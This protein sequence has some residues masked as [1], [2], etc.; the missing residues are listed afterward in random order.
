[1][2]P[3]RRAPQPALDLIE[4]QRDGTLPGERPQ[5]ASIVAGA[6]SAWFSGRNM[7]R[8][9]RVAEQ[10]REAARASVAPM[11]PLDGSTGAGVTVTLRF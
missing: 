9:G 10:K 5:P 1:V 11:L 8:Y 3:V 6:A 2:P 4:D 7:V